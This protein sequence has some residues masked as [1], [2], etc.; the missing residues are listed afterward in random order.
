MGKRK[1]SGAHLNSSNL[2]L[3]GAQEHISSV[4]GGFSISSQPCCLSISPGQ[5]ACVAFAEAAAE[6]PLGSP[7]PA[8]SGSQVGT[9]PTQKNPSSISG[10]LARHREFLSL[11]RKPGAGTT[12]FGGLR[13]STSA[14]FTWAE[15]R[16]SVWGSA[17]TVALSHPLMAV[18]A[19]K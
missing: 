19:G 15:M 18:K 9:K 17:T 10:P 4:S 5:A 8:R 7:P 2:C 13:H 12:P 16:L 11:L 14:G 3:Y 1:M 6:D